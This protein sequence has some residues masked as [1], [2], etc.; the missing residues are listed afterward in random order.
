MEANYKRI[1]E[2]LEE[3]QGVLN[4]LQL[5]D[6]DYEKWANLK[7]PLNGLDKPRAAPGSPGGRADS[8]DMVESVKIGPK[9]ERRRA[10]AAAMDHMAPSQSDDIPDGLPPRLRSQSRSAQPVKSQPSTS[11]EE[12]GSEDMSEPGTYSTFPHAFESFS[13]YWLPKIDGNTEEVHGIARSSS[14]MQRRIQDVL[15]AAMEEVA[16]LGTS[17]K[18][19]YEIERRFRDLW[20]A[21]VAYSARLPEKRTSSQRSPDSEAHMVHIRRCARSSRAVAD[22]ELYE[23]GAFSDESLD[24]V[25]SNNDDYMISKNEQST[26]FTTS[27][28]SDMPS[29]HSSSSVQSDN[30]ASNS[31]TLP[32]CEQSKANLE[33]ESVKVLA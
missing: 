24:I 15:V 1:C 10:A 28:D 33:G 29:N 19:W 31:D 27:S 16:W 11:V 3:A 5:N 32:S 2:I 14:A 7:G 8:P 6:E 13:S 21:A 20:G 22:S 9:P 25:D 12:F 30:D 18:L 23:A 26:A 4:Q 17:D